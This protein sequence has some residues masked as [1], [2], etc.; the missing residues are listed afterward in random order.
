MFEEELEV[1]MLAIKNKFISHNNQ[2]FEKYGL[3]RMEFVILNYIYMAS[4]KNSKVKASSLA[5]YFDVS[6]PAVLHKLDALEEKGMVEKTLDDKD[7][8]IKYYKITMQTKQRYEELFKRQKEKVERYLEA[9][10]EEAEHLNE[11]LDRTIQFLE[12]E[13]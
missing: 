2:I 9:L 6:I 10:G 3:T 11:I 13:E 1:K 5:K 4:V 8:R 7:K 12:D